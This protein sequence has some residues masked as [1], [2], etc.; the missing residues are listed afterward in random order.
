M[1]EEVIVVDTGKLLTE[2]QIYSVTSTLHQKVI[3][4]ARKPPWLA[5]I[6]CQIEWVHVWHTLPRAVLSRGVK[7]RSLVWHP[8]PDRVSPPGCHL[9]VINHPHGAA[10]VF[11][12]RGY[13]ICHQFPP[14]RGEPLW[15]GAARALPA[16]FLI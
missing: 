6:N 2:T 14:L 8:E 11:Y 7:L 10:I 13:V 9:S 12:G 1:R 5:H 15:A 16:W 3:S 4:E